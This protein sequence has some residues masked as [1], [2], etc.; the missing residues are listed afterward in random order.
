MPTDKVKMR[1]KISPE[2]VLSREE[3]INRMSE[4]F[5]NVH[6]SV[7]SIIQGVAVALWVENII[8]Y[9]RKMEVITHTAI[10]TLIPYC[11]LSLF[12]IVFITYEYNWFVGVYRWSPKFIDT[13]LPFLLGI[14]EFFPLYFFA[15]PFMWWLLNTLLAVAGALALFNTRRNTRADIFRDREVLSRTRKEFNL[16]F[17]LA[18]VWSFCLPF[19][20]FTFQL[21]PKFLYWHLEEVMAFIVVA[22][23]LCLLVVKDQRFIRDLHNIYNLEY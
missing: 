7:I 15:S 21:T 13:L 10:I 8:A 23:S 5:P 1:R 17:V 12:A 14:G 19:V 20:A 4:S 6:L 11:L 9:F 18:I 16:S 3:L 2:M 22:I